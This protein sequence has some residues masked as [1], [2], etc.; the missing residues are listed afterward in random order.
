MKTGPFSPELRTLAYVPRWSILMA[1]NVDN[2][3][4]HS[5]YVT[6]YTRIVA[7]IIKWKGPMDYAMWMALIHD[8]DEAITSDIPGPA[9]KHLL[10]PDKSQEFIDSQMEEKMLGI[11]DLT[12]RMEVTDQQ[13]DEAVRIVLVAD[14]LDAVLFLVGQFR[15]GNKIA[16]HCIE[17]GTKSLEGAW[18]DLP[19][20]EGVLSMTWQTVALPSI[21]AHYT[22]GGRGI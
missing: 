1:H 7:D 5:Y 19:A 9:K 22:E 3:A 13:H 21:K 12:E 4:Q 8:A 11:V 17:K 20:E 14:K 6:L 2:V 10:D 15:M 16:E 18:R